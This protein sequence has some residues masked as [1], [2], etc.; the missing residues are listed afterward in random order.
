MI[1]KTITFQVLQT[2][3]ISNDNYDNYELMILSANELK[4]KKRVKND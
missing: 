3:L 4:K 2:F 1:I